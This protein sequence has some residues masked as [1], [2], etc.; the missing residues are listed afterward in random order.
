[1]NL[2]F[3][4]KSGNKITADKIT[5]WVVEY[6]DDQ[7]TSLR[8]VQTQGGKFGC[9]NRLIVESIDLKQIECIVEH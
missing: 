2:T 9:K 8:V 4:M 6:S 1:M 3:Y 7:L 5:D